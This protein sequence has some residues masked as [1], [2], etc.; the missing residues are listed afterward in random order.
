MKTILT[1]LALLTAIGSVPTYAANA[2]RPY[3]NVDRRNDRGNDTGD[4]RVE[5]LNQTQLDNARAANGGQ[6]AQPGM[7][8][9]MMGQPG[10]GQPMMGQPGMTR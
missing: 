5:Q 6:V 9:P 1:A 7:G 10:M 4:S 2:R 8:Q 3:A